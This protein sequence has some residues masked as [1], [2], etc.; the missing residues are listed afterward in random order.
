MLY[1]CNCKEFNNMKKIAV[2]ALL[3][4][5]LAFGQTK[6]VYSTDISWWGY[7]ISKTE[8]SSHSGKI[9]LKSGNVV[10]K[11]DQIVGGDFVFDMGSINATDV[12][13]ERQTKLNAHLKDGDFFET[14][15]FPTGT[16]V[17][18]SVVKNNDKIYN[19]K[20]NG[21]LTIKGKTNPVSFPAKVTFSKGIV[22][23]VSDKFSFDRQKFDVAYSSSMK[24][25]LIKDDVDMLVKVNAK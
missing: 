20:I 2:F 23:I 4:S 22:S 17:I 16:Y 7:K 11:K 14:D 8:S 25:V 15:K 13:G 24:D 1:K 5:G 3:V 6:K 19:Y 18:T 10:M 21:N 9:S 12:S